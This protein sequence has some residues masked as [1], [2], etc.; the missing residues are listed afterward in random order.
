M[1]AG[2]TR[3]LPIVRLTA[4]PPTEGHC[5]YTPLAV[6]GDTSTVGHSVAL[7]RVADP[8]ELRATRSG[9][10]LGT[11]LGGMRVTLRWNW[12]GAADATLVVA[13]QGAAPQGPDD[14]AAITATVFR[15]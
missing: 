12:A 15:A 9:S 10:G 3:L 8:S 13:R 5:Y 11:P 4:T 14:P 2:S 7:S 6:W 1:V